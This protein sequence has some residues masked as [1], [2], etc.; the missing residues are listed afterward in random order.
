MGG[1]EC[2][3]KV[4][5]VPP[6]STFSTP[7][8][9]PPSNSRLW[10]SCFAQNPPPQC[11][12]PTM[13]AHRGSGASPLSAHDP[14]PNDGTAFT[15]GRRPYFVSRALLSLNTFFWNLIC[16]LRIWQFPLFFTSYRFPPFF[17]PFSSERL[18]LLPPFTFGKGPN[19]SPTWDEGRDSLNLPPPVKWVAFP[20]DPR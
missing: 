18:D 8:S 6:K 3:Q 2:S 17:R 12:A 15:N 1:E 16:L 19:P 13:T 7:L 14:P 10:F 4:C 9:R 5:L 20:S 11:R